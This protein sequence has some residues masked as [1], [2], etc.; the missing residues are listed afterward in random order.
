MNT[1]K[2]LLL[3][4]SAL[5]YLN[6]DLRIQLDSKH[7]MLYPPILF[8]E[9]A[10]QGL[11]KPKALFNFNNTVNVRHWIHRAKEDLL[12]GVSSRHYNIGAKIPTTLISV[13]P[14]A[15]RKRLEEQA[16]ELV[17]DIEV[18]EEK[19]KKR[20]S[21]LRKNT[22]KLS[23]LAL[24][25]EN[26]PDNKLLRVVNQTMRQCGQNPSPSEAAALLAGGRKSIAKVRKMFNADRKH[27]KMLLNVNT[28]EDAC[29]WVKNVIY[30]DTE[31]ILDFICKCGIIPLSSNEQ[32]EIF[33]RFESQ[34]KPHID[35]FAPYAKVAMQLH[36]TIFLFL[37]ENNDTS[38]PKGALRDFEYLYYATDANVRFI[39]GDK[40]HKKCIEE[41]PLL[42]NIQKNFM[43]FPHREKD[44]EGFYKVLKSIGLKTR[45]IK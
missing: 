8:A 45:K 11:D 4:K 3:D 38:S 12:E 40:W 32:K 19:L 22:S 2:Y 30:T 41:I 36:L 16:R 26:I 6:H 39:S 21:L 14:G 15:E 33:N 29:R 43:F 20:F 7:T 25:H 31:S 17:R 24:N 5:M 28:L 1:R 27:F 37:V 42:K 9:I 44:E 35:N 23:E 34:G 18:E 13:Y 10:K